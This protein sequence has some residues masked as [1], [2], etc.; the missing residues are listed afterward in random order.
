MIPASTRLKS[1]GKRSGIRKEQLEIA[2][3]MMGLGMTKEA[4]LKI[5]PKAILADW[6]RELEDQKKNT[7]PTPTVPPIQDDGEDDNEDDQAE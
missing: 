6:E 5:L 2:S 3:M 4:I 1:W 7:L